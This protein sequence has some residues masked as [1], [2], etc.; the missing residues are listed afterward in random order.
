M[1][2]FQN[3]LLQKNIFLYP[4]SHIE[5]EM[6]TALSRVE[7]IDIS[8]DS[9]TS[10]SVVMEE[11]AQFALWCTSR[12]EG[13]SVVL[14]DACYFLDEQGLIFS[15]SPQ[16][17]GNV[18]TRYYGRIHTISSGPLLMQYMPQFEFEQVHTFISALAQFDI[19]IAHAYAYNDGDVE[20]K[21]T[22]GSI[23]FFTT[24]ESTGETLE[25]LTSL[26]ED[27]TTVPNRAEFMS[28][29]QYIDLRFGKKIFLKLS[30]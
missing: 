8:F 26:L 14:E 1:L 13:E 27:A 16:F 28:T 17:S 23:L 30:Q 2:H 18:Y 11:R 7:S 4:R 24:R 29:V 21:T 9:L 5:V 20:L 25:N 15:E 12:L 3:L 22:S 10:I 19:P 6:R